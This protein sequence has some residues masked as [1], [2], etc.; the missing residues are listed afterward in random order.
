MRT[1]IA[2]T[3]AGCAWRTLLMHPVYLRFNLISY[4]R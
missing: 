3:K 1:D 2:T 4:A